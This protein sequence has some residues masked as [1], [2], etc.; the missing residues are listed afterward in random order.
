MPTLST[1]PSTLA[2]LQAMQTIIG[3][4]VLVGGV[5]PFAAL[6]AA[7]ATRYGVSH[8]IFVGKP[9]DFKDGYL[10]QCNLWVPPAQERAQQLDVV[11]YVGRVFDELEVVLQC[12]V[13]LRT[14]WY[15]GEQKVLQM[16]DA[17]WPVVL[18]HVQLG[19]TVATVTESEAREGRGLCY[20]QVAG[21]DYRCYELLWLVRQQWTI[22]GGRQL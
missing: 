5:S 15:A 22:A 4:E 2:V 10:P 9:K 21:V 6:S 11:G 7:D 12:F 13:D 3:N 20:E 18:K 1:A 17:L 19:G 14:D 8:A 16:R